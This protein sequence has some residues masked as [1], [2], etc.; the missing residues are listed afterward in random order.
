MG[1]PSW[2]TVSGTLFNAFVPFSVVLPGLGNLWHVSI[3]VSGYEKILRAMDRKQSVRVAPSSQRII[4]RSPKDLRFVSTPAHQQYYKFGERYALLDGRHY[5]TQQR[6]LYLRLSRRIVDTHLLA[7]YGD[8]RLEQGIQTWS[9]A[10]PRIGRGRENTMAIR[11]CVYSC[12]FVRR[13]IISD[14]LFP[15]LKGRL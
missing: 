15:S 10:A 14:I 11:C 6:L 5:P 13:L 2:L 1:E 12:S 9:R 8:Q 4:E 7:A 3:R